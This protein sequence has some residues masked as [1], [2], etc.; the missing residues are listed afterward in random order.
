MGRL[1]H[2]TCSMIGKSCFLESIKYQSLTDGTWE[3]TYCVWCGG[4]GRNC[5]GRVVLQLNW[6]RPYKTVKMTISILN[7]TQKPT[8]SQCSSHSSCVIYAIMMH[9]VMQHR[10]LGDLTFPPPP[11]WSDHV[12]VFPRLSYAIPLHRE[13]RHIQTDHPWQLMDL[14]GFQ[15]ELGNIL[16]GG[17]A[18]WSCQSLS[19]N[20]E[21]MDRIAPVWPFLTHLSQL[22]PWFM[23]EW[24]VSRLPEE[25]SHPNG[26]GLSHP[27]QERRHTADPVSQGISAP[28]VQEKSLLCRGLC[29][30]EHLAP[31]GEICWR[32]GFA[33][34]LKGPTGGVS[35]WKWLTNQ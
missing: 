21:A 25:P 14:N 24:Y 2:K 23:E 8:M 29:P 28:G 4:M 9:S 12:L 5:W 13:A 11:S 33:S 27:H 35:C 20:L 17:F 30:L 6:S 26:I 3:Q 16:S 19:N 22:S 7:C 32:H 15:M 1:F 31:W 18:A 10:L 34:W